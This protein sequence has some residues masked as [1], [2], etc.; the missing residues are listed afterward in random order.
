MSQICSE[1]GKEY[2][3]FE[4]T[5]PF[6]NK[7]Y[8]GY[9][10]AENYGQASNG[11]NFSVTERRSYSNINDGK[12]NEQYIAQIKKKCKILMERCQYANFWEDFN[13]ALGIAKKMETDLNFQRTSL[14]EIQSMWLKLIDEDEK[15]TKFEVNPPNGKPFAHFMWLE[16][17]TVVDS[18]FL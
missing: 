3:L 8:G 17:R 2:P 18:R 15:I 7:G 6:M 12:E 1:F 10:S 14:I 4:V 5:N 16:W 11:F 9:A 13:E